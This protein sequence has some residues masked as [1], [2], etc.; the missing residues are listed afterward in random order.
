M[1]KPNQVLECRAP[2]QSCASVNAH[3]SNYLLLKAGE[4]SG[5]EFGTAY[6]DEEAGEI[7]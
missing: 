5:S 3:K 7:D 4:V 1:F 2:L 6:S